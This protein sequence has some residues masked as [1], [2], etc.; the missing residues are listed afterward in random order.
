MVKK[1]ACT[2]DAGRKCLFAELEA[3][4]RHRLQMLFCILG[5]AGFILA[6]ITQNEPMPIKFRLLQ[7][8]CA[9]QFAIKVL[10]YVNHF[11][12]AKVLAYKFDGFQV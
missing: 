10:P 5:R 6:Y 7:I 4:P 11:V 8:K 9:N 12:V 3:L 1:K 2:V